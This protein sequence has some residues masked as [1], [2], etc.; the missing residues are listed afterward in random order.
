MLLAR[1][2]RFG[3]SPALVSFV[4]SPVVSTPQLPK[5]QIARLFVNDGRSS[6]T[7]TARRRATAAEQ[8]MAPA[9]ETGESMNS[10]LV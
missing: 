3:I 4:R 7:R 10:I 1:V 2:C 5:S 6:Y 9:G 8:A